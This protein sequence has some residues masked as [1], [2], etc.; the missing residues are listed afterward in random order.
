MNHRIRLLLT[1]LSG[2]LAAILAIMFSGGPASLASTR[3]ED[4]SLFTSVMNLV[5]RNYVEPVDERRLIRGALEGMLREL[6]PHS[7]FMDVE[8]YKEMQIDT[9]GEFH[10]LGIEISKREDGYVEVVSPIEGTPAHRA[11]IQSRDQI[12][13]ICPTEKPESWTEACGS[14]KN[15]SLFE[16]VRLMRGRKG[17]E[18]TIHIFREGFERP[19]PVEIVRDVVQIV[20][21][22]GR[23]LEDGYAY[24]RVRAFQ[25]RTARDLEEE[26]A[27]ITEDAPA[28]LQGVVLDL[29]DNPGGLLD[30]AVKVADTWLSD[31]LIVYTQ[32]RDE[33]ERQEYRA[34]AEAREESYPM[35]V[36]VNDGSASASEIVAGALQDHHRALVLGTGT[37]GKGS[38]QTVY[39]LEDGSGLR[40]TT[41]RYY[42]PSGRSIQEV[43][44]EP[45]IVVR[46]RVPETERDRAPRRLKERDLEGHLLNQTEIEKPAPPAELLPRSADEEGEDVQLARALEVLKSWTYFE[47]LREDWE[48][49]PLP[50]RASAESSAPEP[51]AP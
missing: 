18:I 16:A 22:E 48:P 33:S 15:M 37:F 50:A 29:R 40:L 42:T 8:A 43:G 45:D 19:R 12:V 34:R 10:G 14:T 11:G 28:G 6:D 3:Y 4:L 17:T 51:G 31:G 1:F 46:A 47:R 21:V 2:V 23:M 32:G 36:L 41:A 49:G 26:L 39:P 27:E 35:V 20:S 25:E 7:A 30:Q 13:S 38:V 5:R 24:L 44:I 9:R